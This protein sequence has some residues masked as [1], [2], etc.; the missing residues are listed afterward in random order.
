MLTFF[1][2]IR[3]NLLK[4]HRFTNY[5]FYALGE[6][7]LVV[8]GILIA[9]QIN[10]WH[11]TS[12]EQTKES[13]YLKNLRQDLKAQITSIDD[14]LTYE[15]RFADAASHLITYFNNNPFTHLDS[16]VFSKLSDLHTRKTFVINAST[17]TDL[18]SSGNIDLIKAHG[19]KDQLIQYYH[20]LERMEKIIQNNN[21]FL[22]DEQFGSK[23]VELGYFYSNLTIDKDAYVARDK[24]L[25]L[26]SLYNEELS[27]ISENLLSKPENQ[28][29][30]MN[31]IN[32]RHIVSLTHLGLME[33]SKKDTQGLIVELN[34][35]IKD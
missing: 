33:S 15:T 29:L 2:R 6:I 9:L 19:F 8:L 26:T 28:L 17:Y 10:N 3:Q 31:L 13:N 5:I 34:S 18:L 24:S 1:R 16:M 30:L 35:I 27:K 20:N 11:K 22:V 4:E 32:V 23:Y 7:V 12:V 25:E 21:S 14:Q